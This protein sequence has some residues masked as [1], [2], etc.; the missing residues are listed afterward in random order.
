MRC[1]RL[2]A[3]MGKPDW[4]EAE[5]AAMRAWPALVT[6]RYDGW[7]LRFSRGYTRRANSINPLFTQQLPTSLKLARCLARYQQEGL[8]P[9]FRIVDRGPALAVDAWLAAHDW[10]QRDPTLVL[11]RP[12]DPAPL[13]NE[14]SLGQPCPA[15]Q[16]IAGYAAITG[17]ARQQSTHL[18][19]LYRIG[20]RGA[21]LLVFSDGQP[22][23]CALAVRSG[24]FVVLVD[25]AVHP[26]HRRQGLATALMQQALGWGA[27]QGGSDAILQVVAA[28]SPARS[29]YGQLGFEPLYRYWYRHRLT[30]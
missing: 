23:A 25:V 9:V 12:L 11:W 18:E 27:A 20:Q 2:W 22:L 6:E 3:L 5:R 8:E 7:I 1:R 19:I 13:A 17:D 29:L 24:S 21:P 28:N 4:V 16:W 26:A 15:D 30:P 14:P 10:Q